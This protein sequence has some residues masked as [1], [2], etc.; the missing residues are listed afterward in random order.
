MRENRLDLRAK[1]KDAVLKVIVERLDAEPVARDKQLAGTEVPDGK[2]EHASQV[3]HAIAAVLFVK[4]EDGFGVAVRAVAMAAGLEFLPKIAMVVDF[5]VVDDAQGFVFVRDGLMAGSE[6]N[7]AQA[8][9]GQTNVALQEK[10]LVVGAA[11]DDLTVHGCE[12]LAAHCPGPVLEEH[13][14]DSTHELPIP[15]PNIPR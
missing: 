9:H 12:G 13:T 5:A 14:A 7:D 15:H 11:M 4:M 2:C 10:A 6:V 8:A 1:H 3:Q